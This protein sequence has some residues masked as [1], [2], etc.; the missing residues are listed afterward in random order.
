MQNAVYKYTHIILK[1][2][3]LIE[4]MCTLHTLSNT[5]DIARI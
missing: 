4:H 2:N 3:V 1:G 5:K